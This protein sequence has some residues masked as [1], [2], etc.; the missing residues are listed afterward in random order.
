L[1][2]ALDEVF[3]FSVD[4]G[5]LVVLGISIQCAT[6]GQAKPKN[7]LAAWRKIAIVYEDRFGEI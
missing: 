3:P 5:T 6:S 1:K 4:V 2:T 7:H